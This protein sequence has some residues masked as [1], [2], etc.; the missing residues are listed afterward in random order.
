MTLLKNPKPLNPKSLNPNAPSS[1]LKCKNVI[2]NTTI[3][4]ASLRTTA[5]WAKRGHLQNS[6]R[7]SHLNSDNNVMCAVYLSYECQANI[8]LVAS[9]ECERH[10]TNWPTDDSICHLKPCQH[11]ENGRKNVVIKRNR[12]Q[13][14]E[15]YVAHSGYFPSSS[16]WRRFLSSA[17]FCNRLS[18]A[19]LPELTAA[20][21][22][23]EL[24]L[25]PPCPLMLTAIIFNLAAARL[26]NFP[27]HGCP[28]SSSNPPLLLHSA[29]EQPCLAP[30]ILTTTLSNLIMLAKF[31][32]G[33]AWNY[34]CSKAST[35]CNPNSLISS[36]W[37]LRILSERCGF[38][39]S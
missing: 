17:T 3:S 33:Q 27:S 20:L 8:R 12:I 4:I 23:L 11:N 32:V 7:Y 36:E 31:L 5:L 10:D 13:E 9:K 26:P 21:L 2:E 30:S 28:H 39:R 19:P 29:P 25:P 22:S 6:N 37:E 34:K 38:S 24:E 35:L 15:I 14:L 18:R 16:F 1:F